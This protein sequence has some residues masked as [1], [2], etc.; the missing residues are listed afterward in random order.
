MAR[1]KATQEERQARAAANG[2]K[3]GAHPEKDCIRDENKLTDESIELQERALLIY[4][5]YV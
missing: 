3:R 1:P 2:S 4:K 5:E